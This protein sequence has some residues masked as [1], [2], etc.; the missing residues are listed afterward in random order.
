MD[1]AGKGLKT[2]V[3]NSELFSLDVFITIQSDTLFFSKYQ[4]YF[5]RPNCTPNTGYR[6]LS[7]YGQVI[8]ISITK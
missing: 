6:Y 8:I 3:L 1:L 4:Q 2:G 5:L 7:Y